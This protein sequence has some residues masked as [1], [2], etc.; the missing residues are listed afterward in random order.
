MWNSSNA[1]I[2][3]LTHVLL[4]LDCIPNC[5]SEVFGKIN[6][7]FLQRPT[8]NAVTTPLCFSHKNKMMLLVGKPTHHEKRKNKLK[9]YR[10]KLSAPLG[11]ISV[12][13]PLEKQKQERQDVRQRL[14]SITPSAAASPTFSQLSTITTN[15]TLIKRRKASN[16][17]ALS[18]LEN[19]AKITEPNWI[20]VHPQ[21]NLFASY[22]K[23][24]TSKIAAPSPSPSIV[25][26]NTSLE[27]N[28]KFKLQGDYSM[29]YSEHEFRSRSSIRYE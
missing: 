1:L 7:N 8:S 22:Q 23:N 27:A 17:S 3:K 25:N 14:G 21:G 15:T 6:L 12:E 10:D 13:H 16:E 4:Y 2:K 24:N 5:K 11:Y 28:N 18:V 9:Q 19:R 29:A 26:N 20:D